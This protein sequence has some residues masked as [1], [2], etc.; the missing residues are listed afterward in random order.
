LAEEKLGR[1]GQYILLSKIASGGM[2]DVY[3]AKLP[4]AHGIG[5]TVA[6]KCVLEHHL[7]DESFLGAKS[8]SPS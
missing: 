7:E 8:L 2:A 1:I 4:G 5:K 6:L 3:K